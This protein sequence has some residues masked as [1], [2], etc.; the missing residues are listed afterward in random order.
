MWRPVPTSAEDY[1]KSPE[2][3][4]V[5]APGRDRITVP[6][7]RMREVTSVTTLGDAAA[8]PA[9]VLWETSWDEAA[10]IGKL[11]AAEADDEDGLVEVH[12]SGWS[13]KELTMYALAYNLV[14]VTMCQAAGRQGVERIGSASSTR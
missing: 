5:R 6:G 4:M 14:R 10:E 2:S 1:R 8:Y 11:E 12:D 7:F 9:H 13:V 3:I